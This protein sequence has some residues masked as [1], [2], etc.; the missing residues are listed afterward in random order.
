MSSSSSD[1]ITPLGGLVVDAFEQPEKASEAILCN[2]RGIE[3]IKSVIRDPK[4]KEVFKL[5]TLHE[6]A[7]H[8]EME[9]NMMLRMF[10]ARIP[11]TPYRAVQVS[12]AAPCPCGEC[13]EADAEGRKR[14]DH[15]Y[16]TIHLDGGMIRYTV[17][18]RGM[19]AG[20][21][22][23]SDLFEAIDYCLEQS[24]EQ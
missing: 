11:A 23:T 14:G 3:L 19:D 12:L 24:E 5:D 4:Y 16:C 21:G 22:N 1:R 10:G 6:F 20:Y 18:I 8:N 13:K 9:K 7:P 2:A 17:I 15:N